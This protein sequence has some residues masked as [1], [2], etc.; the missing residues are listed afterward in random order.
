MSEEKNGLVSEGADDRMGQSFDPNQHA[1]DTATQGAFDDVPN[2][3]REYTVGRS[4]NRTPFSDNSK[5]IVIGI[6]DDDKDDKIQKFYDRTAMEIEKE[7]RMSR[8]KDGDDPVYVPKSI[9]GKEVESVGSKYVTTIL[10]A[11]QE[12]PEFD[13]FSKALIEAIQSKNVLFYN[14]K[15]N[16]PNFPQAF[17]DKDPMRGK[18]DVLFVGNVPLTKDMGEDTDQDIEDLELAKIILSN[19]T[20]DDIDDLNN[21]NFDNLRVTDSKNPDSLFN[22][23][24]FM[25]IRNAGTVWELRNMIEEFIEEIDE[26]RNPEAYT[27]SDEEEEDMDLEPTGTFMS[28]GG[29]D[30]YDKDGYLDFGKLSGDDLE[31]ALK[32]MEFILAT[33]G[34][35]SVGGS[36]RGNLQ[37]AIDLGER[38]IKDERLASE[39]DRSLKSEFVNSAKAM[40]PII[41][42][43][44][45]GNKAKAGNNYIR[46]YLLPKY[47]NI[48][49]AHSTISQEYLSK[50]VELTKNLAELADAARDGKRIEDFDLAEMLNRDNNK[51][52]I[53]DLAREFQLQ[54]VGSNAK[55]LFLNIDSILQDM[56]SN[57]EKKNLLGK[58]SRGES[59]EVN[60]EEIAQNKEKLVKAIDNSGASFVIASVEDGEGI[61]DLVESEGTYESADTFSAGAGGTYQVMMKDTDKYKE[62]SEKFDAKQAEKKASKE[63][64]KEEAKLNKDGG[65][66]GTGDIGAKIYYDR[67]TNDMR[68]DDDNNLVRKG[69][70]SS[71]EDFLKVL[72]GDPNESVTI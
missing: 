40:L 71:I 14:H 41:K 38:A 7:K 30:I 57:K 11:F 23:K 24:Q 44:Y 1:L 70:I 29:F 16:D 58:I 25:A 50:M 46:S 49:E 33:A 62:E 18:Y 60:E 37:K 64:A 42:S 3:G 10:K 6:V 54:S 26:E 35:G 2:V 5:I 47:A 21:K 17:L 63:E 45:S 20:E 9:T 61:A 4:K 51:T 56:M 72:E 12:K 15:N 28:E 52:D 36:V 48:N 43:A 13:Q 65:W 59:P 22:G 69:Q 53:M 19:I 27:L 67:K 34:K 55:R 32:R 66:L 31:E 68:L 8:R 39:A